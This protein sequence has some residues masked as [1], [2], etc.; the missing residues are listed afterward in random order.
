[1]RFEVRKDA[2]YVA[3]SGQGFSGKGVIS[4]CRENLSAKGTFSEEISDYGVPDAQLTAK[5]RADR[6]AIYRTDPNALLED[7]SSEQETSRDYEGRSIFELLQNADDAMAPPGTSVAELIGVKGLGFKAVLELSDTPE[8]HSP[9]FHFGFDAS[10]SRELLRGVPNADL[11]GTFRLPHDRAPDGHVKRLLEEGFSTVIRLPFR[12]ADA[13]QQARERLTAL[14]PHFLLLSQHLGRVEMTDAKGWRRVL[15]RSGERPSTEGGTAILKVL[16]GGVTS[17]ERWLVWFDR[18]APTATGEKLL[19]AAIGVPLDA[20]DAERERSLPLYVFYPTDDSIGAPFLV[21]AAFSVQQNRKHLRPGDHDQDLLGGLARLA[22]RMAT[23]MPAPAT[24]RLFGELAS[25]TPAARPPIQRVMKLLHYTLVKA[26]G[27]TA[28][29]PVVAKR[30]HRVPPASA[31]M[32]AH[33]FAGLLN[34]SAAVLASATLCKAEIEPVFD[35]LGAFRAPRLSAR[36]HAELFRGARCRSIE[37]VL[38][39]LRIARTVC[40]SGIPGADLLELLAGAPIWMTEGGKVRALNGNPLGL[41]SLEGWPD[42]APVDIL[43]SRVRDFVAP[44]GKLDPEWKA[45]FEGRVARTADEFVGRALFPLLAAWT[46]TEW[47]AQGWQALEVIEKFAAIGGW[48][49]IEP[50]VP[51]EEQGST[52]KKLASVVRV[53]VGRTWQLASQCYADRSLKASA[54][55]RRFFKGLP[56]RFVAGF[57]VAAEKRF[58]PAR[59][60]ALL[61]FLGVSWEPKIRLFDD[62][63][64][65]G[66]PSDHAF[67]QVQLRD[68]KRYR[69]RD[70]FLEHFPQCV[71]AERSTSILLD[72]AQAVLGAMANHEAEYAKQWRSKTHPPTGFRTFVHFQLRRTAYLPATPNLLATNARVP[73]EDLYLPSAGLKGITPQV[74][75]AG[76]SEPQRSARR[77]LLTKEL[78]VKSQLPSSWDPWLAWSDQLA[79]AASN[80]QH[81]LTRRIV[82][83]FYERFLSAELTGYQMRRPKEVVAVSG[84]EGLLRPFPAKDVVWIDTPVIAT[85]DILE[86]LGAAGLNFLPALLALGRRS[87][88]RLGIGKASEKIT[89]RPHYTTEVERAR[90]QL[91]ARLVKRTKAIAAICEAKRAKQPS[92]IRFK[93][94]RGLIVNI[95]LEGT[96]VR[97]QAVAAILHEGE[98]LINLDGDEW[99]GLAVAI[100]GGLGRET[101]LRYRFAALLRA[102]TRADVVHILMADNIPE[103][104]L[105]EIPLDDD[106]IAP[107]SDEGPSG[108]QDNNPGKPADDVAE[109]ETGPEDT[110]GE[111]NDPGPVRTGAAG[112]GSGE[113][114]RRPLYSGSAGGGG[115]GGGGSGGGGGPGAI[116]SRAYEIGKS[117]EEWLY[118]LLELTQPGG[119]SVGRN[120]RDEFRRETDLLLRRDGREW[121]IEV[122]TLVGERLYWS[123]LERSKAEVLRP[124]YAMAL[125]APTVGGFDHRLYWCWDPLLELLVCDRRVT[126]RWALERE[127]P[128]LQAGSWLPVAGISEPHE[129]PNQRVAAVK[130]LEA[131]LGLLP[132]DDARLSVFWNQIAKM[133]A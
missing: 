25:S 124:R 131:Q 46:D 52:R 32:G 128:P 110:A 54:E 113:L 16:E 24:L 68:S 45:L 19:S 41:A 30:P 88:E 123:D 121:H 104:R 65:A 83:D 103:Y 75:L 40:L 76:L 58:S 126:W 109:D 79:R 23:T 34:P 80:P 77:A 56:D 47:A 91:Q 21:H 84:P 82:R 89:L 15:S 3:N 49:E 99:D 6:I 22:T 70:W 48:L 29:V 127:G 8:V 81:R 74:D 64:E 105:R 51:D 112:P 10:A 39:A 43:H 61:R 1:M 35:H 98:W 26:V 78:K 57:P 107:L 120:E 36:R 96:V 63:D 97:Q 7:A 53:P 71:A 62:G 132:K 42:W 60:R 37:D 92:V 86:A 111:P 12:S 125:L 55:L 4:V 14:P 13:A 38:T 95:E 31:T 50:L 115:G 106:P 73:A 18:W 27:A 116:S 9:P 101:D 94:V 20:G 5:L 114:S 119:W 87:P 59:W 11:V 100:A 129:A 122:K 117:G 2:L 118:N 28:F 69:E 66:V 93:A 90:Q 130:I 72:M 33:G 85:S 133:D 108:G 67:M 17:T 44:G 102:K